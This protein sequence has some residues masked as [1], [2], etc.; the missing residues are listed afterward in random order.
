MNA[1]LY[2]TALLRLAAT[3][4]HLGRLEGPDG[5]AERRSPV[6]GSRVIADVKLDEEGRVTALGLDVFAC[7]LGQ[8][9][10]N[11]MASHAIG[12]RLGELTEARDALATWLA[13]ERD[14]P[15][16][17]PGLERIVR[18]RAHPGRHGAI[19]L[20]FE[21]IVDAVADARR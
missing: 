1:P 20:P 21:A 14:D 15:G 13:G 19:R 5:S 10:A 17:W 2:D 16:T 7:A 11:L 6:C 3:I 4:P 9:S 12:R 18:A 8:A